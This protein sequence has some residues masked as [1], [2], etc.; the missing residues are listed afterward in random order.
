MKVLRKGFT[1]D[2]SR[3]GGSTPLTAELDDRVIDGHKMR[4]A[5]ERFG[6]DLAEQ[7]ATRY[8]EP[9]SGRVIGVN[10]SRVEFSL[11]LEPDPAKPRRTW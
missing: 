2:P 4:R 3:I 11:I 6:R 7:M 1:Q 8:T 10:L 9:A 5:L